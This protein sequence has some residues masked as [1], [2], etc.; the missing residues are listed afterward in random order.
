MT[1]SSSS[2]SSAAASSGVTAA[3]FQ[4]HYLYL[5]PEYPL[6]FTPPVERQASVF[7]DESNRQVFAV[8]DK[9]NTTEV[10]VFA[11][12]KSNPMRYNIHGKGNIV[13]VKFSLDQKI[14]TVQK[15]ARDIDF[16]N[17]NDRTE[18]TYS[19]KSKSATQIIGFHWTYM[20]ELV[21]VTTQGIELFKLDP[22]KQSLKLIKA[23]SVA[24][25]WYNYSHE[26]RILLVSTSLQA[27]VMY[28][29]H[30]KSGAMTRL[31]RFD[32]ELPASYN[33]VQPRLHES[34]LTIAMVYGR[35]YCL[36]VRSTGLSPDQHHSSGSAEIVL[37]QLTREAVTKKAI[38]DLQVDGK[39][40]INVVDNVIVV[41][42]QESRTSMLFDI[43]LPPRD[44]YSSNGLLRPVSPSP[45]RTASPVASPVSSTH[46]SL[47][48]NAAMVASEV[49]IFDHVLAPLSIAPFRLR[50]EIK[51][52]PS[53]DSATTAANPIDC[54]LYAVSWVVFQPNLV[55]D[56]KLGVLWQLSIKLD[57]I[58]NMI[59][60]K[61]R[62][63]DFLLRRTNSKQVLLQVCR[64][65]LEEAS[66]SWLSTISI[67]FDQLNAVYKS[68]SIGTDGLPLPE[69]Q[70]AMFMSAAARWL[71]TSTSMSAAAASIAASSAT[72]ST[73]LASSSP[74]SASIGSGTIVVASEQP[75][76]Q[77]N[78]LAGLDA[79]AAFSDAALSGGTVVDA[80]TS[81]QRSLGKGCV[82]IDQADMF[83][84]VFHPLEESK[85]FKYRSF[86]AV[87]VEYIRSL[88][89][90]KIPVQHYLYELVINLLVRNNRY[91][92]LHQFLQ[93]H[94]VNDSKHVACLLLSL[95]NT[96][97][98]A[99][100]LALDML[101]RLPNS[102][103]EIVDVF[104]SKGAVLG[105]LRY[106][107]SQN[108]ESTADARQFLEVAVSTKDDMLFYTVFKFFEQ[109]NIKYR[110]SP[111]FTK[112]D[113]CEAY[114]QRF[115]EH[116]RSG[117]HLTQF[118][119]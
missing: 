67:V 3:S 56:A 4:Q 73:T 109:R 103:A 27:N 102:D 8:R 47:L 34:D 76:S 64:T 22:G 44:V 112:D 54:E 45:Y 119:S 117:P 29:F 41:H 26:H 72:A 40:A 14:L 23:V 30:F 9:D 105:A 96:Y 116:F 115:Q 88:S 28:G 68:S 35:L 100:Q 48:G 24:V 43:R 36:H 6:R 83:S 11:V 111:E 93:Y 10:T 106:I 21:L 25:N 70:P 114:V 85:D 101:K 32:V 90:F 31:P 92:Q 51:G 94:V 98:P 118:Q 50:N 12:N 55:I 2:S 16:I 99:Y 62:L 80:R 74:R 17:I 39:F 87:L 60:D 5:S 18:F 42:R 110:K 65:L 7:F 79:D 20:N 77:T 84:A 58:V 15:T 46:P 52:D 78:L 59:S 66:P 81:L 13:S 113:R 97:P 33:K 75:M 63:V 71:S 107:R 57:A 61:N 108:L 89:V 69:Q 82:V 37:Y 19:C 86:V 1:S 53:A 95:E 38:L 91:Y 49:P 104:L